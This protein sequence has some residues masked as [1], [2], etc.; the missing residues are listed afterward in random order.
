MFC[1]VEILFLSGSKASLCFSRGEMHSGL[2]CKW[3]LTS[4]KTRESPRRPF[5]MC[6]QT[7]CIIRPSMFPRKSRRPPSVW[8]ASELF[9]NC[10][11]KTGVSL[12]FDHWGPI[13][14]SV[15]AFKRDQNIYSQFSMSLEALKHEANFNQNFV[16]R[17]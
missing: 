16:G 8:E 9:G 10:P 7:W 3:D 4:Q 12:G 6:S 11:I 13:F 17:R 15:W 14:F 5:S 1:V 2:M